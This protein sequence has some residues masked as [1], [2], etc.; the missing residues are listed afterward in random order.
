MNSWEMQAE[1]E[2]I[3]SG[4]A[5]CYDLVKKIISGLQVWLKW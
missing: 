2:I 5:R 3:K 1:L 4:N